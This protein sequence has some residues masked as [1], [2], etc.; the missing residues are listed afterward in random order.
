MLTKPQKIE[1]VGQLADILRSNSSL[2]FVD[3]T[4]L[5]M[6]ELYTLKKDLK[7]AGAGWKALKKSLVGFAFAK[8]GRENFDLANHK[9]SV[10]VVYGPGESSAVMAKIINDFIVKNKKMEIVGGF[11]LG[12]KML[13]D[14]VT[15][16]AKL[17]PREVLLSQVLQ[18]F[19]SPISGF[20]RVLDGI[21]KKVVI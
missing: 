15:I 4:G 17:P 13:K 7:K 9:S 10:A 1:L 19:M 2:L 18:M 5:N 21:S 16:L 3:F 6:G 20:A 11:L 8:S 12:E 14:A